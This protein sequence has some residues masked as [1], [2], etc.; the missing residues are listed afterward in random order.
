MFA[1]AQTVLFE[2]NLVAGQQIEV[3]AVRGGEGFD[4]RRSRSDVAFMPDGGGQRVRVGKDD[5]VGGTRE[6]FGASVLGLGDMR[7]FVGAPDPVG[8][9]VLP[10]RVV[11]A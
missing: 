4:L 1:V 3:G 8:G 9:G 10:F 7:E 6:T 11:A 2:G 5:A